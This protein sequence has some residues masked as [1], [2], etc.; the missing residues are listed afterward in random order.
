MKWKV[1]NMLV[2]EAI[3]NVGFVNTTKQKRRKYVG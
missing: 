3:K 1:K 2:S